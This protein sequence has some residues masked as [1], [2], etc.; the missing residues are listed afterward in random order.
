MATKIKKEITRECELTGYRYKGK[1][2]PVIVSITPGETL[3]FRVKGTQHTIEASL[4]QCLN[5]AEMA[6][7]NLRYKQEMDKYKSGLRKRK[8]KKCFFPYSPIYLKAI[9]SVKILKE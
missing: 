2:R 7:T 4:S 3:S 9:D 8:P 5:L 1:I 6:S